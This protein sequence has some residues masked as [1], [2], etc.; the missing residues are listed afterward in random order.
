MS[1]PLL[2]P[3]SSSRRDLLRWPV[4]GR[5]LRWRHARAALQLGT[6]TLAGLV[7]ADGLFGP[8]VSSANFAGVLPWV[9]WRGLVLLA[10]LV[11]GN[12]FCMACPFMLPRRV[13][14]RVF[15]PTRPWPRA[16]R[17]KWA[18][19]A[20]LG[21]FLWSYEA[22]DL[23]DSPWVTAWLTL[24]YFGAAFA[25]DAF[26]R[27]AAFCKHLC[28]IGHFNFVHGLVSPFEVA[29]RDPDRCASCRT[30]DCIRGRELDGRPQSGCELWLFQPRKVGNMDC[31]FCLDC[32]QACP[33]DNVGLLARVPALEVVDDPVRSGVGRF[34]RRPDLAALVLVLTFAGFVNAFGMVAALHDLRAWTGAALGL[35]SERLFLAAVFAAGL[36]V[37]PA[38]AALTAAWAARR[39]GGARGSGL[40]E[41]VGRYAYVLAPTGAAMWFA[42]HFFHFAIG[43]HTVLPIARA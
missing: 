41:L 11:L 22:F 32:V 31:T 35:A 4:V 26:F 3:P 34:G 24:A 6:G 14:K 33:H 13:A 36:V 29:V 18:A 2:A 25:V 42:H 8:Q 9:H 10:L 12:V 16:L 1:L 23:W 20:L 37:L 38:A 43:A 15:G 39:L 17:G 40:L 5:F 19:I 28:P 21:L 7:I 27:G 30:K